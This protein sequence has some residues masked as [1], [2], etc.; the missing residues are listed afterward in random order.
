[1][2]WNFRRSKKIFPGVRINLSKTG[3]GFSAG[4]IGFLRRRKNNKVAGSPDSG[5]EVLFANSKYTNEPKSIKEWNKVLKEFEELLRL[6]ECVQSNVGDKSKAPSFPA[7]KNEVVFF[8]SN[9]FLTNYEESEYFDSGIAYLTNQRI[10]F[11]GSSHSERWNIDSITTPLPS[12]EKKMLIIQSLQHPKVYAFKFD[13][14]DDYLT[15]SFNA[16][17]VFTARDELVNLIEST[18]KSITYYRK[19]EPTK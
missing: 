15:F 9:V 2:A 11:L 14:R 8:Q 5:D 19:L 10:V 13:D 16:L 18:K 6:L 3:I 4:I 12:D 1:M 17:S 7:R